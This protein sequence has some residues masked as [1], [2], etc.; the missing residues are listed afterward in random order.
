MLNVYCS[1]LIELEDQANKNFVKYLKND[2]TTIIY[3]E[4]RNNWRNAEIVVTTIQSLTTDNKYR[5][6]FSPT[7]FDLVISDEAHRSI[8]GNSRAVFE[9]FVGYKL[10]LT[11]TPKNYLKNLDPE[12]LNG[13]DI[14]A[15][16]RRQLLDTYITFGCENSEPTFRYT[17]LN[18]VKDEI[19]I[20]PIVVDARTDI[21]T[22]L[23]SDEGYSMMLEGEDG[24]EEETVFKQRDFERKFFSDK[25][26]QIFCKTF[27]EN[28]LTDPISK[29][30]GKTIVFCVSQHH[31]AKITQ[32]LNE[33]AHTLW[34]D[35]YNSDFA[36]QVTSHITEAQQFT[37]NFANNNLSGH[38]K[39]IEGYKSSKTRVCVTV[40]MMTTGYDCTDILNICLMRPIF[41]PSDFVQIKGRGTRKHWFKMKFKDTGKDTS[42]AIDKEH[43]KLFDFFANCE[44]FEEKFDYDEVLKLPPTRS[45]TTEG[46]GPPVNIDEVNIY[47][48]DPLKTIKETKIGV[49]GMKIDR[50]YFDSFGTKVSADPFIKSKIAEG[51]YEEVEAYIK[52][53][54][55]DKPAEY[56]DLEK[57]QKSAKVDRKLSLREVIDKVFGFIKEFKSKDD[58]LEEECSNFIAIHKPDDHYVLPIKNFIKTYAADPN[59]REIIESKNY[60]ELNTFPS[61]SMREWKELNGYRDVLP[62]YIKDYVPLSKYA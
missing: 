61:F 2:F 24:K 41:S 19:L 33:M 7:D 15:W 49:D 55:F 6:L 32:I 5:K 44:Y 3:K 35:K 31:A 56:F 17:L 43:F 52:R 39:F 21:T 53:E 26:N 62:S 4:N 38:T 1:L 47:T 13:Q 12:K 10:G 29:E 16:E 25:T 42:F 34:P 46:G 23:L 20:N 45:G 18:G 9:Y 14:R 28:A 27:F 48:P 58:L 40:G 57:L 8:S 36:I 60:A 11:A 30:I 54:I 50:E 51:N 59:F 37:I 22:Q